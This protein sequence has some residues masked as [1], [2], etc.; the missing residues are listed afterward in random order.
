MSFNEEYLPIDDFLQQFKDE[1]PDGSTLYSVVTHEDPHDGVGTELA[2]MT[3]VDGCFPSKYGDE[4]LF[5]QHQSGLEDAAL[6]PDWES[7][8]D[9]RGCSKCG[10]SD[11][12]GPGHDDDQFGHDDPGQFED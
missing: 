2:Q 10:P 7:F 6:R 8:Y 9:C 1:I 12:D 5:F 3:V 11:R 4:H